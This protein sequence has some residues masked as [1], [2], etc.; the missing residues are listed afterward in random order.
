MGI[1]RAATAVVLA[2]V[3]G[4]PALG[5][6]ATPARGALE[7]VAGAC[8]FISMTVTFSSPALGLIPSTTKVDFSGTGSCHT[9][10]NIFSSATLSG[11][12]VPNLVVTQNAMS[13]LAGEATGHGLLTTPEL[14]SIAV[15]TL[16]V[17]V[18]G[19]WTLVINSDDLMLAGVGVFVQLPSAGC[20][21]GISS[22]NWTGALVFED[23]TVSL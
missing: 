15:D 12:G 20:V 22:A 6:G 10:D 21:G 7:F 8:L 1:G 23:P 4:A 3:I 14:G 17:H 18:G 19:I 2:F 9:T 16:L 5:P 11:D 13:C